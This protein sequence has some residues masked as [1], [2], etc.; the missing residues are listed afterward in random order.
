MGCA[1]SPTMTGRESPPFWR[2]RPL[3]GEPLRRV[4]VR[5][6]A[7]SCPGRRS[8]MTVNRRAGNSTRIRHSGRPSR[9][10]RRTARAPRA[11]GPRAHTRRG[12][13]DA[14]AGRQQGRGRTDGRQPP[15]APG[16]RFVP[17]RPRTAVLTYARGASGFASPRAVH[18]GKGP[19][20]AST[21]RV[22]PLRETGRSPC[23]RGFVVL[24]LLI[25][26]G[27]SGAGSRHRSGPAPSGRTERTVR[28][29]TPPA[30]PTTHCRTDRA[31]IPRAGMC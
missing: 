18:T 2:G 8:P 27:G 26:P 21:C 28:C 14:P 31:R 30:T 7:I 25:P 12:M 10:A 3:G 9:S 22:R 23:R 15:S 13:R 16:A 1:G 5:R 24:L 6:A 19:N 29:L 20:P 11:A 17:T 4:A